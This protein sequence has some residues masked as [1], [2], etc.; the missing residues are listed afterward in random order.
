MTTSAIY[1]RR[2]ASSL[3]V[4]IP[5]IG[6]LSDPAMTACATLETEL[7][8]SFD[9]ML[10]EAIRESKTALTH[11]CEDSKTR[12]PNSTIWRVFAFFGI[13]IHTTDSIQRAFSQLNDALAKTSANAAPT[14]T[15]KTTAADAP[16]IPVASDITTTMRQHAAR[17][18]SEWETYKRIIQRVG[19]N[20]RQYSLQ[21]LGRSETTNEVNVFFETVSWAQLWDNPFWDVVPAPYLTLLPVLTQRFGAVPTTFSE[22][23]PRAPD[24]TPE[25]LLVVY[26]DAALRTSFARVIRTS[27]RDAFLRVLLSTFAASVPPSVAAARHGRLRFCQ[28]VSHWEQSLSRDFNG[29]RLLSLEDAQLVRVSETT[30]RLSALPQQ[31]LERQTTAE[32]TR[33][34][35]AWCDRFLQLLV[36]GMNRFMAI[37]NAPGMDRDLAHTLTEFA[38]L[39]ATGLE[40]TLRNGAPPL[41]PLSTD[42]FHR[43][44]FAILTAP[45]GHPASSEAKHQL[46][47][48][49]H[50]N[51]E[52]RH[53]YELSLGTLFR[54]E[55]ATAYV[56]WADRGVHTQR[57]ALLIDG[58]D[59]KVAPAA[60]ASD[61]LRWDDWIQQT[62]P[63]MFP[64]WSID[65]LAR[66]KTR[67]TTVVLGGIAKVRA[68]SASLVD[69]KSA[70]AYA[71]AP[72][73]RAAIE[74][75]RDETT[76]TLDF[77]T[78]S[79]LSPLLTL[80]RAPR[81]D[82]HTLLPRM[83]ALVSYLRVLREH[84]DRPLDSH[85]DTPDAALAY[86]TPLVA[87]ARARAV[88]ASAVV[89][90]P[91]VVDML[92]TAAHVL[93]MLRVLR[94]RF[95]VVRDD[96]ELI[97]FE[98]LRA[99]F[100]E[101]H[102]GDPARASPEVDL[103][104]VDPL[105]R[106]PQSV[107]GLGRLVETLSIKS[108]DAAV[109]RGVLLLRLHHALPSATEVEEVANQPASDLRAR[110][111]LHPETPELKWARAV[112]EWLSDQSSLSTVPREGSSASAPSLDQ[113]AFL[114][115]TDAS[116]TT[117]A[118]LTSMDDAYRRAMHAQIATQGRRLFASLADGA[119]PER[120]K[121][122]A[123]LLSPV[124]DAKRREDDVVAPEPALISLET[125]RQMIDAMQPDAI[126][127][128]RA[129]IPYARFAHRLDLIV[130]TL[131]LDRISSS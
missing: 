91:A 29:Q 31:P 110:I 85:P 17:L 120:M 124:A 78:S 28:G 44:A 14:A 69:Q 7:V 18:W 37:I 45:P 63:A 76:A 57:H 92:T 13:V 125:L 62:L 67:L 121:A 33:F 90:L 126:S 43:T 70:A 128:T 8:A 95:S 101:S 109:R 21:F 117:L 50:R 98:R 65:L 61:T 25:T 131:L 60:A 2:L 127:S 10:V 41:P 81:L 12:S 49:M 104:T 54:H 99:A 4:A 102:L 22:S 15:T 32:T 40:Q 19:A 3:K 24:P 80:L 26:D 105:L 72:A 116:T 55:I 46:A 113:R 64:Q 97:C 36:E 100:I 71:A 73:R 35:R 5:G 39:L 74:M 59:G 68:L 27:C 115:P 23:C 47:Q 51:D 42:D 114:R 9:Q 89:R 86:L 48:R 6:E 53:A 88:A 56:Q 106:H 103:P 82:L 107:P 79:I 77:L 123:S 87:F 16:V 38:R 94:D 84:L 112:D 93:E 130:R 11:A 108:L 1:F 34:T 30:V 122:L 111:P 58:G 83:N 52:Q 129:T 96:D 119:S 75:A 118:T 66:V 20:A